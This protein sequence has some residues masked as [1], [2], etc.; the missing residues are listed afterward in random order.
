M[1]QCSQFDEFDSSLDDFTK[2]V[3][4][5]DDPVPHMEEASIEEPS[6]SQLP[7]AEPGPSVLGEL[8]GLE[9]PQVTADPTTLIAPAGGQET[10]FSGLL[11]QT[12]GA[13]KENPRGPGGAGAV[14]FESANGVRTQLESANYYLG[15]L[16]SNNVAEYEGILLGLKLA[17][18][19]L[20]HSNEGESR[21]VRFESDSQL[22]VNQLNGVAQCKDKVLKPLFE[23]APDEL[24]HAKNLP[25]V[26]SVELHYI[27]RRFNP[28]ADQLAKAGIDNP[29][30]P[31]FSS[32]DRPS[33]ATSQCTRWKSSWTCKE[34]R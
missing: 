8:H 29:V 22:V 19:A 5:P 16:K 1:R 15:D 24:F 20:A 11:V 28:V 31:G 25:N 17:F 7:L 30:G 2:S 26:E 6:E 33:F 23:R 12:D 34:A 4:S 10:E 9:L 27:P 14:S 21:K 32:L 18:N 3:H 13:A